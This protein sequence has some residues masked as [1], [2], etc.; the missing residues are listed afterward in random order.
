MCTTRLSARLLLLDSH[1]YLITEIQ[2][3]R[4]SSPIVELTV[5][6]IHSNKGGPDGTATWYKLCNLHLYISTSI[7]QNIP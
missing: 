2:I 5:A 3:N 6:Q 7:S 4:P 1:K